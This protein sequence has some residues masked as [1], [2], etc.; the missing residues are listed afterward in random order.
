MWQ[1]LSGGFSLE[2]KWKNQLFFRAAT[3]GLGK[4]RMG[5]YGRHDDPNIDNFS[6]ILFQCIQI[7]YMTLQSGA[8]D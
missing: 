1:I 4:Y 5:G 6:K 2:K 3:A 8:V 7:H